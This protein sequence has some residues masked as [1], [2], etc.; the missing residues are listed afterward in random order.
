MDVFTEEEQELEALVESLDK[1]RTR[2]KM[3]VMAA[4][5]RL[6]TNSASGIQRL[7][8]KVEQQKL[9]IGTSFKYVGAVVSDEGSKLKV[10]LRIAQ[11]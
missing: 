10:L 8:I 11:S 6:M 2:Y 7:M 3:E 1:T 5:T 9:G 4:K